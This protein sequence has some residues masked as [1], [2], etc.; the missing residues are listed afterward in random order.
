MSRVTEPNVRVSTTAAAL[1]RAA[2]EEF[3]ECA[4]T[5]LSKRGRFVAALSGGNTPRATCAELA[6]PDLRE[7]IDW[8]RVKLFQVDERLVP[9]TD[10]GSNYRM[11]HDALASRVPL[12]VDGFERMW[13]EGDPA[14]VA[15]R[16]ERR[17]R[18]WFG[19]KAG[20]VP[21]FD[22]ILLG[23]GA[24]GHTASLFP[25]SPALQEKQRLVVPVE[26]EPPY[27][28]RLTLTLPVLNNAASVIFLVS[29]KDKA[30]TVREVLRPEG[31]AAPVPAA[32]VQ[33]SDGPAL[34]LLD[35]AAASALR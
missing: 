31:G 8:A 15:A 10:A 35:A 2:A 19:T 34:W 29:G 33:P 7:R 1:A 28:Q 14:S 5:A 4:R 24:D 17:M 13:S 32:Y 18:A 16:A 25:N 30:D 9:P 21:R 23:M 12:P 22:L 3:L 27:R 6:G 20:E 11:L 26:A